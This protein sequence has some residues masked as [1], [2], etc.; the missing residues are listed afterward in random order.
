MPLQPKV[1]IIFVC[2]H[3][4]NQCQHFFTSIQPSPSRPQR[5]P[6]PLGKSGAESSDD[7]DIK[8][9]ELDMAA[10]DKLFDS[11]RPNVI[12]TMI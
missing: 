4:K 12:V 3:E 11:V 9:E 7:E 2:F 8:S 6:P 10:L 1:F 5:P